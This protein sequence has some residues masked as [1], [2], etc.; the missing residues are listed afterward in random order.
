MSRYVLFSIAFLLACGGGSG[1][2]SS[3]TTS[4]PPLDSRFNGTWHGTTTLTF[5]GNPP[6]SYSSNLV[7]AAS[8]QSLTAGS[9]CPDGSGSATATGSGT[10]AHW[11]GQFTCPPTPFTNCSSV[12]FT[13]TSATFSLNNNG[14]L[15]A[16]GVGSASGC[17]LTFP[18]TTTFTGTK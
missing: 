18:L 5:Q 4:N 8:G 10:S 12:A 7:L 3:T 13:Y 17:G 15:T 2:G 6:S 9:I 1:G 16:Q 14:T 11:E